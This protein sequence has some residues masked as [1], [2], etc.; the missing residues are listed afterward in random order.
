[1]ENIYFQQFNKWIGQREKYSD[2][3][4]D[5]IE[6]Y[7]GTFQTDKDT[8]DIVNVIWLKHGFSSYKNSLLWLVN[9]DEYTQLGRRFPNISDT[10]IVFARTIVGNLFI[11]DKLTIG[12]SILYLNVHKGERKI[13]STSFETFFA[14][15]IPAEN[16][17]KRECYGKIEL[18]VIEKLGP[19]KLDE[20]LTFV[21]ALALGGSES[22]ANMQKVKIKEHLEILAQLYQG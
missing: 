4:K 5:I 9:P 15:D 14:F 11:F 19:V 8:D 6:K 21:P 18:K 7:R 13:I 12:D 17:W 10:A 1:M 20:C 2:V 3:P 16:F 22:I